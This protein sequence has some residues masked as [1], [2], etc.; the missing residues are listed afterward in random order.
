MVS[1][2]L[3]W[4]GALAR[5]NSTSAHLESETVRPVKTSIRCLILDQ[6]GTLYPRRSSL[7]E[8][9]RERTKSWLVQKL[10]L[11]RHEIDRLYSR[12]QDEYP[13]PLLGFQSLGAAV[14]EYHREVFEA[15]DPRNHLSRDAGLTAILKRLPQA[16]YIVTLAS[17]AYSA[18]LQECLGVAELVEKTYFVL[19]YPP[20]YSKKRCYAAIASHTGLAYSTLC[21][22]GDDFRVDILPALEL[23]CKAI[24]VSDTRFPGDHETIRS[25]H[26]LLTVV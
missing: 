14:S 26:E 22:V 13:N 2:T 20:D 12:L 24:H 17:P 5:S 25:I 18:T 19:D 6:D 15:I 7:A 8:A 23:G 11:P 21:V 4:I 1:R 9:L 10:G 16:K 3:H